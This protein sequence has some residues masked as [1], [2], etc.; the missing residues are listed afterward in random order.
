MNDKMRRNVLITIVI[1]LLAVVILWVF[2]NTYGSSD[3][4]KKYEENDIT[5]F[6]WMEILGEYSGAVEY[7]NNTPYFKDVTSDNT[8]FSIVQAAVEWGY[9]PAEENFNGEEKASGRF[10][11]LTAMKSI[12]EPKIQIC[13]GLDEELTDQDYLDMAIELGIIH[14]SQLKS[15]MSNNEA[16]SV[17]EKLEELYFSTL[18][19]EDVENVTYQDH[20]Y[21][22]A[23]EDIVSYDKNK[24]KIELRNKTFSE[25]DVIVFRNAV[26]FVARKVK[27]V[28]ENNTY[29][30]EIPELEECVDSLVESDIAEITFQDVVNFYGR[31]N[32]VVADDY[33][34]GE[35]TPL[36]K[37]L[38]GDAK[39]N[40]FIIN[41]KEEDKEINI[42]VTDNDTGITY[43]LPISKK[44][45]K[46]YSNLDITINVNRIFVGAQLKYSMLQ[47]VEYAN[48]AVDINSEIRGGISSDGEVDDR[49]LLFETPVPIGGG[50]VGVDLQL[51]LVT[52]LD[53]EIYLE[54]EVPFQNTVHY[55]KGKGIRNIKHNISVEEPKIEASAKVT[56]KVRIAPILI[57][58][59]TFPVLDAEFDVGASARAEVITRDT[60]QICAD[61]NVAFPIIAVMVGDEDVSYRGEETFLTKIGVTGSWEIISFDE[62]PKKLELHFERLPDGTKQYVTECTYGK[63]SVGEQNDEILSELRNGDFSRFAGSYKASRIDNENYGG[64]EDLENLVLNADGTTSGGESFYPRT[65]PLSVEKQ[66]DGS[67]F[68]KVTDRTSF[69]IYPEG[70]IEKSQ[71]FKESNGYFNDLKGKVCINYIHADGGV[72]DVFYYLENDSGAPTITEY[73]GVDWVSMDD[74]SMEIGSS[75]TS[76]TGVVY[77]VESIEVNNDAGR[78]RAVLKSEDGEKRMVTNL[79]AFKVDDSTSIMYYDIYDYVS[80]PNYN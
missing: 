53:G 11:A 47:G 56:E 77:T 64:G 40:G 24:E 14:K 18:W 27:K 55:E 66:E 65:K 60:S 68:C 6:E 70:V 21:E 34:E 71:R 28:L 3:K 30:L 4:A 33:Q 1:A 41:V 45:T 7:K 62:A 67:Y 8:Y 76:G 79:P 5:R 69:T 20:V 12:G 74:F 16:N 19:P 9:I 31:D 51:Y 80:S 17:I 29:S 35:V 39:S 22:V 37:T 59:D 78:E 26:F 58:L 61:V 50:V 63:E 75:F 25:G 36:S 52:T 38:F 43:Q 23:D 72:M 32:L 73:E 15:G 54:A 49:L 2:I 44:K 10:V 13:L 46:D 48:V 57:M 42:Y